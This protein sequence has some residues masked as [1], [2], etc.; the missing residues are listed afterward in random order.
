MILNECQHLPPQAALNL[1]LYFL[2]FSRN[3]LFACYF[4]VF[5]I[6]FFGGGGREVIFQKNHAF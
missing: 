3:G 1:R 5:V 2:D 4:F 6:F